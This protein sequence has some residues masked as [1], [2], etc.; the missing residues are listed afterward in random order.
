MAWL[1]ARG[2][3]GARGCGPRAPPDGGRGRHLGNR[4]RLAMGAGGIGQTSPALICQTFFELSTAL[5]A[6]VP[7]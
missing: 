2:D 3:S 1:W 4:P 6:K 5:I 7:S